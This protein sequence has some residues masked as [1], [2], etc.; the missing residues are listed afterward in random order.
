MDGRL[1]KSQFY[2]IASIDNP[3]LKS[4]NFDAV[5]AKLSVKCVL[6]EDNAAIEAEAVKARNIVA[7][8]QSRGIAVL[9]TNQADK[10]G[11]L[12]A[13][14]VHLDI[15]QDIKRGF[16]RAEARLGK[17]AIVGTEVGNSRHDAMERAEKNAAY[18]AFSGPDDEMAVMI[19]W[20]ADLFE[21]PS[22]AWRISD[23]EMAGIYAEAG[24]DFI[25]IDL[26]AL[27]QALGINDNS[28][29]EALVEKLADFQIAIDNVAPLPA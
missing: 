4:E 29:I 3:A 21:I 6:I 12:G 14:G 28:T 24:A 16:D 25:A 27:G 17:K 18:I 5:C 22:V 8:I 1:L 2:L 26:S 13:D 20:W 11:Q 15:E 7:H 23:P 19:A 10:A 9:F